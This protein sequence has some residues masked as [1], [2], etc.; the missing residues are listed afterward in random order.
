MDEEGTWAHLF[1][2]GNRPNVPKGKELISEDNFRPFCAE[3]ANWP[4]GRPADKSRP[5]DP[6]NIEVFW[7]RIN[8][9][10]IYVGKAVGRPAPAMQLHR[11]SVS[12][13]QMPVTIGDVVRDWYRSLLQDR[14]RRLDALHRIGITHGDVKDW[15]FRVPGDSY[16]TVLYDSFA[17][18]TFSEKWHFW[19]CASR[20]IARDLRADLIEAGCEDSV[21]RA[22]WQSLD[23]EEEL[24]ELI[25][26]K[27]YSRPDCRLLNAGIEL[28]ISFAG[29][30]LSRT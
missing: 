8:G 13:R 17:A 11:L 28:D 20:D 6:L 2:S 22:L 23:E 9:R 21:D 14:L 5:I 16:D 27:V 12:R 4:L 24:L 7:I 3:D 18:Y 30:D 25:I 15:H 10:R 1:I 19:K 29:D 26:L